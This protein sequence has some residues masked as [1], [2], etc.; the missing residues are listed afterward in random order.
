MIVSGYRVKEEV[1]RNWCW[2]LILAGC[3]G[4]IFPQ[5]VSRY[6]SDRRS[7]VV[8]RFVSGFGR[9]QPRRLLRLFTP[10]PWVEIAGVGVVVQ[11]RTGIGDL[12]A[13][14]RAVRSRLKLLEIEVE[15]D[16]VVCRLAEENVWLELLDR[17]PLEYQAVFFLA[18]DKIGGIRIRLASSSQ[19]E[20]TPAGIRFLNWLRHYQPD[21]VRRLLPDGRFRFNEENGR[22]LVELVRR[23]RGQN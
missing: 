22:M 4:I 1:A 7:V 10:E 11:G 14:G 12:L 6:R 23:W 3:T 18:G 5:G 16:S 15:G 21:A 8:E 13:Y 20:L 9:E 17:N 2:L 19:V